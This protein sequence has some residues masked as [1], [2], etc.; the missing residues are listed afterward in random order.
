MFKKPLI[1]L[2]CILVIYRLVQAPAIAA[3][4]TIVTSHMPPFV[5]V[6]KT[7]KKVTGVTIKILDELFRR[8][9]LSFDLKIMPWRRAYHYTSLN[10]YTCAIPVQRNQEREFHYHWV[11]P[12]FVTTSAIYSLPDKDIE[13][14]TLS[15]LAGKK[16]FTIIGSDE[17]EYL[18]GFNFDTGQVATPTQMLEM[19]KRERMQ[20]IAIETMTAL[21]SSKETGI[22]LKTQFS[23]R[24]TIKALA[25]NKETPKA[26]IKRLEQA[27]LV[28]YRDGTIQNIIKSWKKELQE[29]TE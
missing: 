17:Y 22:Q 14:A 10:I 25:C 13:V 16:I 19:L 5:E 28:M 26:E 7:G 23:F 9:N 29:L 1:R 12:L 4:F 8:T 3:D 11:S 21:Q 15:D 24:S 27:L 2:F 18:V 6:N 20:L